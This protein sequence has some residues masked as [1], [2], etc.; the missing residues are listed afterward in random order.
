[1]RSIT[2]RTV[3]VTNYKDFNGIAYIVSGVEKKTGKNINF[4]MR[5]ADFHEEFKL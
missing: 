2:K 5:K 4:V 3:T 1:M